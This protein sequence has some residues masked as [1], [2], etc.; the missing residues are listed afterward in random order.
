MGSRCTSNLNDHSI[1]IIHF[2]LDY[3]TFPKIICQAKSQKRVCHGNKL[4]TTGTN[5]SDVDLSIIISFFLLFSIKRESFLSQNLTI[6]ILTNMPAF[7][8]YDKFTSDQLGWEHSLGWELSIQ[9]EM[10]QCCVGHVVDILLSISDRKELE[11][12]QNS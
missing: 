5:Y 6:I 3:T 2:K 7:H 8:G 4:C 12:C 9:F 10:Q 11:F 1:L